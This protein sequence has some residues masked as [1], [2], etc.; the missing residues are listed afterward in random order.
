[1][2]WRLIFVLFLL[3]TARGLAQTAVEK[4]TDPAAPST[5]VSASKPTTLAI[6]NFSPD[7][8]KGTWALGYDYFNV[9][10]STVTA[11]KWIENDLALDFMLGGNFSP[12][13]S[14]A[15]SSSNTDTFWNFGV[16]VGLRQNI[17]RPIQ[18]VYIQWLFLLS[19]NQSYQQANDGLGYYN[20]S[21]QTQTLN[22]FIGPGFEAFLPFLQDLS[23]EANL[24]LNITSYW[25][26]DNGGYN[27]LYGW[28]WKVGLGSDSST[29][30]IFN[31]AAH[32]YF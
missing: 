8:L 21:D 3:I 31:A 5:V 15:G 20:A 19:Y 29:F 11:R 12:G 16:G 14:Y 17:A 26:E 24:G 32:F 9:L 13:Y 23:V 7:H 27:T 6:E 22:L 2:K 10:G 25:A 30:S 18:D 4:E 1:M 28:N